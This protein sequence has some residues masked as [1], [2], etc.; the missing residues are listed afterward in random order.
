MCSERDPHQVT[1]RSTSPRPRALIKTPKTLSQSWVSSRS[2]YY[3]HRMPTYPR[4]SAP[5]SWTSEQRAGLAAGAAS[6][7]RSAPSCTVSSPDRDISSVTVPML[8]G[9]RPAMGTATLCLYFGRQRP[10]EL[11]DCFVAS[12]RVWL[13]SLHPASVLMQSLSIVNAWH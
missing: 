12:R 6:S 13:I 9:W 4:V 7:P 5:S 10:S 2:A 3:T 1:W 11:A 8:V